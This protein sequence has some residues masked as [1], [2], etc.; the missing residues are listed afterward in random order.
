MAAVCGAR[1]DGDLGANPATISFR[2]LAG[3]PILLSVLALALLLLSLVAVLGLVLVLWPYLVCSLVTR[4]NPINDLS[5]LTHS[6]QD[7][8]LCFTL[9]AGITSSDTK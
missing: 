3:Y 9:R 4:L 2:L 7:C 1:P 5:I 8:A 6:G